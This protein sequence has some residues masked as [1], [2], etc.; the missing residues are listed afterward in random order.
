MHPSGVFRAETCNC[1]V[2]LLASLADQA[3]NRSITSGYLKSITYLPTYVGEVAFGDSCLCVQGL[4]IPPTQSNRV[5][6]IYARLPCFSRTELD[7]PPA[8]LPAACT[9]VVRLPRRECVCPQICQPPSS[10]PPEL[11]TLMFRSSCQD[12]IC[13]L[14]RTALL[15]FYLRNISKT[16]RDDPGCCD[17]LVPN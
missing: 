5:R 6:G 15:H 8:C 14:C 7:C 2:C 1:F 17:M 12:I 4:V 16:Y 10:P 13:E 11:D 9:D 3:A